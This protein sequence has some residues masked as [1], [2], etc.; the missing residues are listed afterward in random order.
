MV[1]REV[2]VSCEEKKKTIAGISQNLNLFDSHSQYWNV[3]MVI[4]HK[5]SDCTFQTKHFHE[6][7]FYLK[8]NLI[9]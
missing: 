1:H 3:G 4:L 8:H 6:A 9:F 7:L 2:F 5:Q